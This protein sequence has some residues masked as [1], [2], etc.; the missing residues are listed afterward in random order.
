M[1]QAHEQTTTGDAPERPPSG[2]LARRGLL[3][4]V[5]VVGA[6]GL[7][8]A[9][10]GS[11]DDGSGATPST[12]TPTTNGGMT[13]SGGGG[14]VL[15]AA[16]DIPVGGGKVFKGP[17]IVVVQPKPGEY[18]AYTAVCTHMGCTVG[19]VENG[20]I[21]C[22]CHGSEYRIESGEVARGPAAKALVEKLIKI[23]DGKII[24]V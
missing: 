24:L 9:C 15:G 1:S 18:H 13:E 12:A 6:A 14:I 21:R 19:S 3:L 7:A 22:P 16:A 11:S 10:G 20:L 23:S 5:S 17:K 4:G 2:D 8:A